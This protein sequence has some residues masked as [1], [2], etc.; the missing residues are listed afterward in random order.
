MEYFKNIFEKDRIDWILRLLHTSFKPQ[1]VN[2]IHIIVNHSENSFIKF[3]ILAFST[4]SLSH[5]IVSW[6]S[7]RFLRAAP[8]A[9]PAWDE[10][11]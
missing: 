7:G 4:F 5:L 6:Q 1:I 2:H 3:E 10:G 9:M 11:G 8:M